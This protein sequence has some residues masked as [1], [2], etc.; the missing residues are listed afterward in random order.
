[1]DRM[2]A[3]RPIT[4]SPWFWAY[5]FGTAALVALALASPKFGQR[6]VQIEREY[7]GR[8]RAAQNLNG[9]EPNVEMSIEGRTI[10]GLRPLYFSL[11]AVAGVAWIV[12]W[13]KRR[14]AVY[15]ST[16]QQPN[17]IVLNPEPQ[18][19]GS[20]AASPSRLPTPDS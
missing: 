5:L 18:V 9:V 6:Q 15:A 16:L 2:A 13:W 20:S 19:F 4:D 11:A 1:M 12:F 8:T 10:I 14:Q 17:D 3:P 7:Q